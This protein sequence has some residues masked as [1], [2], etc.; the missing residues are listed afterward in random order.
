MRDLFKKGKLNKSE[1]KTLS[2]Q[3]AVRNE[4]KRNISRES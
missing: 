4:G 2:F 1:S 3:K